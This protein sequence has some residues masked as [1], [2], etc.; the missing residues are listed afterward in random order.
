MRR[1]CAIV[2][3]LVVIGLPWG[4]RALAGDEI[5]E[6]SCT[7]DSERPTT[8][9]DSGKFTT[10]SGYHSVTLSWQDN[11]DHD[12]G[13][14][15]ERSPDG[16][17]S[18]TPIAYT[19]NNYIILHAKETQGSLGLYPTLT[20]GSTHY[21][22]V[23]GA[24]DTPTN[25]CCSA[26]RMVQ[27]PGLPVM[28]PS[29]PQGTPVPRFEAHV[30]FPIELSVYLN[31]ND[32]DLPK[33]CS[34]SLAT[35]CTTNANCSGGG[36]CINV[37]YYPCK[38]SG[39]SGV[40]VEFKTGS[41]F[42]TPPV[43]AVGSN[44]V[45]VGWVPSSVACTQS[46]A[47]GTTTFNITVDDNTVNQPIYRDY[48]NDEFSVPVMGRAY[49]SFSSYALFS[50]DLCA[51]N[52]SCPIVVTQESPANSN[53]VTTTGLL[54]DWNVDPYVDG[55]RKLLSL[56]VQGPDKKN[57]AVYNPVI[58][59]RTAYNA[60]WPKRLPLGSVRGAL[61][62]DLDHDGRDE[63]IANSRDQYLGGPYVWDVD[64]NLLWQ[65]PTSGNYAPG[66][67]ESEVAV[68]DVDGDGNNE[69]VTVSSNKIKVFRADGTGMTFLSLPGT[70][71]RAGGATLA[72]IDGD[73]DLEILINT[74]DGKS[75][76][77]RWNAT[78]LT[79]TEDT[80]GWPKSMLS[81]IFNSRPS[82]A[83]INGD[84]GLDVVVDNNQRIYAWSTDPAG[85][86][87]SWENNPVVIPSANLYPLADQVNGG[88]QLFG[89]AQPSIADLDSDG[90]LEIVV[91]RNVISGSS[92]AYLACFRQ[93]QPST[94]CA[95][96]T[97]MPGAAGM[98]A[99]IGDF[100]HDHAGPEV[101]LGGYVYSSDLSL[102]GNPIRVLGPGG[103]ALAVASIVDGGI[104][105]DTG[106]LETYALIG[107]MNQS[108]YTAGLTAFESDGT[109]EY[110]KSLYGNTNQGSAAQAGDF[111][112]DGNEDVLVEVQDSTYG[113]I[114]ALYT[115][116][117][118]APFNWKN[119]PWPM[120]GHD[121]QRTGR[122]GCKQ[123]HAQ[124][125]TTDSQCCSGRCNFTCPLECWSPYS[126]QCPQVGKCQ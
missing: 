89:F 115:I 88:V 5:G 44:Q 15:I 70:P 45:S 121:P 79:L 49:D 84:G 56:I 123:Q 61:A 76:I 103:T 39:P 86:P 59:D 72:D 81:T 58:I 82:V 85:H 120:A 80:P 92:G 119:N 22:R 26:P 52:A 99:A 55:S 24:V 64:G 27:M 117:G 6:C 32:S 57:S 108:Q 28:P 36:S 41:V 90:S 65:A 12:A 23:Y 48:R 42:W 62:V 33:R 34:N 54:G 25:R 118:Q 71:F 21:F 109:V 110:T 94:P 77:Y 111:D 112:G 18:W 104:D 3:L 31:V 60:N 67:T 17:N 14:I 29:T 95:Q 30:D 20:P 19:P 8:L 124:V 2:M 114:V 66:L 35:R 53:P 98:S 126:C 73:R 116:T 93:N 1:L 13:F 50:N 46:N 97:A 63:I 105:D 51:I 47:D 125:C 68:G 113:A 7:D 96:A 10:K 107:S 91:G 122:Y 40:V 78:A 11:S 101:L 87:L 9:T 75:H 106:G 16:N 38:I 83:D 43:T 102:S 4:A 74:T 100:D 69:V 37:S